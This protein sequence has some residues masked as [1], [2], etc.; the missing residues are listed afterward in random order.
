MANATPTSLKTRLQLAIASAGQQTGAAG[1]Q[2]KQIC[3]VESGVKDVQR[4]VGSDPT[5]KNDLQPAS[6]AESRADLAHWR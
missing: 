4:R 2:R 6:S 5:G 3:H 1:P